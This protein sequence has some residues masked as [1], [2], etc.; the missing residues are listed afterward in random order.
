MHIWNLET[1]TMIQRVRV[2]NTY[3]SVEYHQL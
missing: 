2:L 1:G 3:M